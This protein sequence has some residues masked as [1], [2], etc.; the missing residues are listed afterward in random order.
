MTAKARAWLPETAFTGPASVERVARL[1]DDWS[2]DWLASGRLSVPF[3]WHRTNPAAPGRASE[4]RAWRLEPDAP[5][6]N[7][8]AGAMLGR[9]I[10][11]HDVKTAGDAALVRALVL[12][13]QA[14]LSRRL[15]ALFGDPA[16][17]SF[18]PAASTRFGLPIALDEG[19][20]VFTLDVTEPL[21]IAAARQRAGAPA[22]RPPLT[23]RRDALDGQPVGIAALL[24]RNRLALADLEKLGPGDVI[25]LETDAGDL[26]DIRAGDRTLGRK[27]ASIAL[28]G[29]R[30]EMRIERPAHEW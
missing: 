14:D 12:A 4:G 24:G 21:L 20:G 8:L 11:P 7:L 28:A 16:G 6:R 13:G 3:A 15:A 9:T 1:L 29:E 18:P 5:A 19:A 17:T 25:T 10:E 27:A 30:F 22:I 2:G 23:R 26:L